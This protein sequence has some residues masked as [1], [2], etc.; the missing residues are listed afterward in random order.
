M[1]TKQEALSLVE[2]A[3]ADVARPANDELLHP[4][5]SDDMDLV[6]L[7]EIS[8][9]RDM[10]EHDI[11]ENY[12]APNFLSPAGFR[13]FL[14][15]YLRFALEHPDSSAA[16]VSATIW[17]LDPSMYDERIAAYSRSMYVL[18]DDA[19]RAAIVAFL[20]AMTDSSYGADAER[21]L[22][23]WRGHD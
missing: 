8:S 22:K 17:D 16:V 12:A 2:S 9:W 1:T 13:Y 10:T 3:F 14:P 15:A 18:F 7:Y 4:D 20:E 11:I 19:Q 21:A 6:E 5:S 23:E